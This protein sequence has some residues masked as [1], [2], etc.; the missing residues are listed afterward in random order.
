MNSK[1]YLAFDL[2]IQ[3]LHVR[4]VKFLLYWVGTLLDVIYM[5]ECNSKIK[6]LYKVQISNKKQFL[7]HTTATNLSRTPPSVGYSERFFGKTEEFQI[8]EWSHHTKARLRVKASCKS[9]SKRP[10]TKR[11][12]REDFSRQ[13]LQMVIPNWTLGRDQC[14]V[15]I[16][17]AGFILSV[18]ISL[19]II[20]I[21]SQDVHYS[22]KNINEYL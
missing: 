3:I 7:F 21:R 12:K 8:S 11:F 14:K 20:F 9:P 2:K 15:R 6:V 17:C 22:N 18:L 5:T 16:P 13:P 19:M 1:N 4:T 10:T